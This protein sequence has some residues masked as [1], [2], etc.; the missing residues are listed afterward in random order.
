MSP[1]VGAAA[2]IDRLS[3]L[4]QRFYILSRL[5]YSRSSNTWLSNLRARRHKKKSAPKR[6]GR[7]LRRCTNDSAQ[8]RGFLCGWLL[9]GTSIPVAATPAALGRLVPEKNSG[10]GK[11]VV[12]AEVPASLGLAKL[13]LARERT[14]IL[15]ENKEGTKF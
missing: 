12:M 1:Y 9:R 2:F 5:T 14:K 8:S 6:R 13:G 3:T 7:V 10:K 11:S 15:G 4:L